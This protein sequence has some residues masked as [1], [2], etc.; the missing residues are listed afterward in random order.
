M[1]AFADVVVTDVAPAEDAAAAMASL[2][3]ALFSRL[4]TTHCPVASTPLPLA[5]KDVPWFPLARNLATPLPLLEGLVLALDAADTVTGK[6]TETLAVGMVR[7]ADRCATVLLSVLVDDDM[8]KCGG[9]V[10]ADDRTQLWLVAAMMLL[11]D[12]L[13][14]LASEA[15]SVQL[16]VP[17]WECAIVAV[18]AEPSSG[19]VNRVRLFAAVETT[20]DTLTGS[21][22]GD[23]RMMADDV[24]AVPGLTTVAQCCL[25]TPAV[26]TVCPAVLT[27]F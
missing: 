8:T 5:P 9:A 18:F 23:V 3:V 14:F 27:M 10:R 17:A 1:R 19:V 12:S 22:L 15:P 11:M 2:S 16:A 21:L 6:R 24:T 26:L 20:H 25:L 4:S 13:G 7:A